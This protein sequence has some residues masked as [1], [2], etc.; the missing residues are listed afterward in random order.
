MQKNEQLSSFIK[1]CLK[2]NTCGGLLFGKAG[3]GKTT[4]L[5]KA[6]A[7]YGIGKDKYVYTSNYF[8]ARGFFDFLFENRDKIILLDDCETILENKVCA[9]FLRTALWE[10]NNERKINYNTANQKRTFLFT[11]KIIMIVNLLPKTIAPLKDR[12]PSLEYNLTKEEILSIAEKEIIPKE[13]KGL[14]FGNRFEVYKHIK[15]VVAPKQEISL[16]TFIRAFDCY[17]F[18]KTDWKSLIN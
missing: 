10:N 4:A 7:E 11:G 8:T 6:I 12:V 16:R 14:T 13:Y 17:S 15:N 2:S 1:M 9:N 18:S 3:H 5:F